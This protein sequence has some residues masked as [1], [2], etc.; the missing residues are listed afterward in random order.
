MVFIPTSGRLNFIPWDRAH[1]ANPSSPGHT[2]KYFNN[3]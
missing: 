2:F 3:N 1:L